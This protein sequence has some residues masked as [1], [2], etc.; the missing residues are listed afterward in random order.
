MK[1]IIDRI[2]DQW[3]HSEVRQPL[4]LRGAR[5]VGKTHSVVDFGKRAFESIVAVNFEE[6]PEMSRCFS[7]LNPKNIIDRLSVLKRMTISPGHTLLFL[8]EIQASKLNS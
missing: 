3:Q 6:Q 2:L 4:L 8:D 1:R 5:Q 7:D